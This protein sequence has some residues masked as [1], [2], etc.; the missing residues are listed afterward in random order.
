MLKA[1][2]KL[3]KKLSCKFSEM[4]TTNRPADKAFKKLGKKPPCKP[5]EMETTNRRTD[6][7]D[8][9]EGYGIKR[10]VGLKLDD[11]NSVFEEELQK[12]LEESN[13][14]KA[15]IKSLNETLE[16]IMPAKA[17]R[18]ASSSTST[19]EAFSQKLKNVGNQMSEITA[20]C[21]KSFGSFKDTL[22]MQWN[23]AKTRMAIEDEKIGQKACSSQES[24]KKLSSEVTEAPSPGLL[25]GY[26]EKAKAV[27]LMEK[28]R[29]HRTEETLR[30][31]TYVGWELLAGNP[32]KA[33]VHFG[34]AVAE[35]MQAANV[36]AKEIPSPVH[37]RRCR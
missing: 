16:A 10:G 6:K 12:M 4:K 34:K 3:W 14:L 33:L 21:D 26:L 5:S 8:D 1:F 25:E 24:E 37:P 36:S 2:K 15:G 27:N 9:P 17:S 18:S 19:V 31:T 11:L 7:D 30:E 28:E 23:R 29:H 13:R 22:C 32:L 20:E 35:G